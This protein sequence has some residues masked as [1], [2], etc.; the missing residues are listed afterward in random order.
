MFQSRVLSPFLEPDT[1]LLLAAR[2]ATNVAS[3]A[4]PF[5]PHKFDQPL[6]MTVAKIGEIFKPLLFV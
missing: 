4:V 6:L 5:K 2:S 1:A 3:L